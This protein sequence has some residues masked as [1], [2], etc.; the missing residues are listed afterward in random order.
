MIELSRTRENHL[1]TLIVPIIV[2]NGSVPAWVKEP[3]SELQ[4]FGLFG[5]HWV[6][7]SVTTGSNFIRRMLVYPKLVTGETRPH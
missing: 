1:C 5:R 6:C 4:Q 7:R 3:T 2:F